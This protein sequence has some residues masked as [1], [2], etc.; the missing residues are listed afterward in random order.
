MKSSLNKYAVLKYFSLLV[1][2][3]KRKGSSVDDQSDCFKTKIPSR[4][5]QFP[6]LTI[7]AN[8][9]G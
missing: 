2:D 1:V 4:N 9:I 6:L 5:G 7:I 3:K 8:F